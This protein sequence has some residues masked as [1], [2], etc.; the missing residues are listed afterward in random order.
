MAKTASLCISNWSDSRALTITTSKGAPR[1]KSTLC[2]RATP[3][4][5]R[6]R[7]SKKDSYDRG[8]EG[9]FRISVY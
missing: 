9:W 2:L 5:R 6:F 1:D 7:S 8:E 4:P 3:P